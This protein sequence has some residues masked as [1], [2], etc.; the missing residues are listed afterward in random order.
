MALVSVNLPIGLGK[1]MS[2]A[3]VGLAQ[4][5]TNRMLEDS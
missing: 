2:K 1:E 3:L 4:N 5:I